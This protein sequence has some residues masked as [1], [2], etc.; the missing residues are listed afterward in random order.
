MADYT[1]QE[2]AELQRRVNEELA[3][4][5]R[6]M[7]GTQDDLRDASVGVRGFSK[8][9]RSSTSD[10]FSAYKDLTKQLYSGAQ[11]QAVFNN[12]IETTATAV[13]AFGLLM[14]GPVVKAVSVAL[15]G[16]A[17]AIGLANEQSDKVFDAY[18]RLSDVG[19]TAADQMSGLRNESARLGYVIADNNEGLQ[20][21]SDII[22]NNADS[23]ALFKGT[24]FEGRQAL[25]GVADAFAENRTDLR[26][27]GIGI[28][29]QNK[30]MANYIRLQTTL[31]QA[32]QMTYKQLADGTNKYLQETQA[33]ASL[34]GQRRE[35]VQQ[36][37]QRALQEQRFRAKI[38][39]LYA[40]GQ[41][42]LARQYQAVNVMLAKQS[43]QAAAGFRA[44]VTGTL[45][46]ADAQKLLRSSS[47]EVL[48][49][50]D[51]LNKGQINGAQFITQLGRSVGETNK[52]FNK[53]AQVTD[54]F[55]E[56]FIDYAQGQQLAAFAQND[57]N[58]AYK[59]TLEQQRQ[60]TKNTEKEL[61]DQVET[62]EGQKDAALSMQGLIQ[63]FVSVAG[64][65]TKG[66]TDLW[67]SVA[68]ILL[69]V[70]NTFGSVVDYIQYDVLG[71]AR[72][73]EEG[74]KPSLSTI[75]TGGGE[76]LVVDESG[77]IIS[78]SFTGGMTAAPGSP[79]TGP[80][81]PGVSSAPPGA[82]PG[83]TG[84]GKELDKNRMQKYLQS[85]ALVESGGNRRA[86]AGTS[87]AQ[88]LFQF[89]KET[90][91]GTTKAMGKNW[92]LE[93]RM[94]PTKAAEAAAYLSRQNA[95]AFQKEFGRTP[96]NEELY[97]MHFLG[98]GGA[99]PFFRALQTNPGI[100]AANVV[101]F[102]A[103]NANKS[104]FD[105]KKTGRQRS[106]GEVYQLMSGKLAAGALGAATGVYQNQAV[107][108]DVLNIPQLALGGITSGPETGYLANLHGREAVLPLPNGDSVPIAL[109]IEQLMKSM[110]D[111]LNTSSTSNSGIGSIVELLSTM[112]DMVTLQ[113]D[114]NDLVTQLLH[115]QRA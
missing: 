95:A 37:M 74:K 94:D 46:N 80:T 76:E 69:R 8:T 91:Q 13:A 60:Q 9:V 55:G 103:Y 114:Q 49:S 39:E 101:G 50:M 51:A 10:V 15:I 96:G 18:N 3:T 90:W 17:K 42:D 77:N 20:Q 52:M 33:L 89:T 102:S 16:L 47:G 92:T 115:A 112:R 110:T 5:G 57:T 106:V 31:G 1:E 38:D 109:N 81:I 105:D 67:K 7:G 108:Q 72:P 79:T 65:I 61:A 23:L 14:G 99:I 68:Q 2:R 58:E 56:T 85:V 78:G 22:A 26:K 88:G 36:E 12:A 73:G 45:D 87:S 54:S 29:E 104:I 32:Q 21:F 98:A 11:G 93:D 30:G 43:P 44:M 25:A 100:T 41:G 19:A 34:T 97:M 66:L 107:N 111:S 71:M 6:L 70:A 75:S 24:V 48:G 4:F 28:N 83:G 86:N 82:A 113:R 35:E 62:R 53:T 27:M 63:K 59:K 40:T 64:D 84:A